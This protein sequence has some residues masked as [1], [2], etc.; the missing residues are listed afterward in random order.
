MSRIGKKNIIIPTD[1]SLNIEGTNLSVMGKFGKLERKINENITLELLN[2]ELRVSKKN[3]EK[4][5]RSAQGLFCVLI[6]NMI[7]GVTKKF[8]KILIA[9]GVGYKFQLDQGDKKK[10]ILSM[11]YSHPVV[12]NLPEDITVTIESPTRISVSGIDKE[13]VG[14]FA[15]K[16]RDVRPPEP[17]KGKGILYD[18]EKILRKVGKT[19]KK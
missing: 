2:N 6:N 10:V 16:I 19:G 4:F 14:L 8:S 5:S 12:I 18:G 7:L 9:E 15:A 1:V 11:G 17:Y 3:D 13:R